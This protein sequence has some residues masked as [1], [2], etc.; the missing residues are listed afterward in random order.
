MLRFY[1]DA[2]ESL[3]PKS[4]RDTQAF[5]VLL[6]MVALFPFA[7][8]YMLQQGPD[9]GE[10]LQ[11][12]DW[13]PETASNVSYYRSDQVEIYEFSITVEEYKRW[14]ERQGMHIRTITS[15]ISVSRYMAYIPGNPHLVPSSDGLTSE[16][17][18]QWQNMISIQVESGLY[19]SEEGHYTAVYDYNSHKCYYEDLDVK[20]P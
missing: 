4:K 7:V 16:E 11:S 15:P 1:E 20:R 9:F 5:Y 19:A 17:F 6:A 12:V 14:A 3:K 18:H 10:N 13:L 8:F 2:L